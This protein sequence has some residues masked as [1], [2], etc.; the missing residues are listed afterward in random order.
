MP[1]LMSLRPGS[2]YPKE[3]QILQAPSTHAISV[4]DDELCELSTSAA[5]F[6]KSPYRKRGVGGLVMEN[7]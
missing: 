7:P 5:C 3:L 4:T 6:L 1:L 2:W